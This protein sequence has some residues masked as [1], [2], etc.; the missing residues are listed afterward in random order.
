[1]CNFLRVGLSF[2]DGQGEGGSWGD[3][4]VPV[5]NSSCSSSLTVACLV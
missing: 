2:S 3:H 5:C 1:M 4:P